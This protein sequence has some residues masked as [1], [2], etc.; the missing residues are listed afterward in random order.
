MR[1]HLLYICS[2]DELSNVAT[3]LNRLYATTVES[4]GAVAEA[5][6]L[7]HSLLGDTVL[8]I[9]ILTDLNAVG[10]HLR[11][12]PVDLLIYDERGDGS[13][14]APDAVRLIKK[15]V[16]ALADLWGPDFLFPM[17][18]VVA[19][20]ERQ[21]HLPEHAFELGQL[22][23]RDVC[24]APK[25]TAALVLWLKRILAE[26]VIK[27]NRV[28]L[29]L[30]GGGLEGFLYQLG[31]LYALEQS[32]EG[33]ELNH[34]DVVSGVSSGSIVGSLFA[35][36]IS[37]D[38]VIK[39]LHQKS[40]LLPS[41]TS[42]AIFDIAGLEIAQ[43]L[44]KQ[45]LGWAGLSP[46]KWLSKISGSVPTGFFRG[47]K[48][49]LFFRDI[50]TETVE[51]DDNF[52]NFKS[53]LF[54]GATD[55][56]SYEHVIFGLPPWDD[57]PVSEAVRASIALPPVFVPKSIKGRWFIDGQ[58]T[59]TTDLELVVDKGCSLV[60]II[61]PLKPYTSNTPGS[62]DKL[63]GVHGFIQTIKALVSSR[64][65]SS[66]KH[67]TE[68]FPSVDFIVFEPDEECAK[69]MSG[70]PMR[71]RIRTEI[72]QLAY[73]STLRKLRERREVYAVK[74][75]K[76]GYKLKSVHTL[77]KLEEVDLSQLGDE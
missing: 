26:G 56:D 43:R 17:S 39:S 23:I 57:V 20:I 77:K 65:E 73:L 19:I 45:S 13:T 72:V 70:S 7:R 15:D 22:D 31:C 33:R 69:V 44:M 27:E 24:V 6:E 11:S 47:S 5:F 50:F 21:D 63:G 37:L 25:N 1:Y 62:T 75:G 32:V 51:L 35:A 38:E 59:K 64:F 16:Q 4:G 76:Y 14:P 8:Q 29:S 67:V 28:G 46:Q 60:V 58:V 74:L 54:I 18:R 61:N 42:G 34:V 41:L 55:Q 52:K 9:N 2:K 53:E 66:L 3:A 10:G 36:G 49:E 40:D 30:S 71:Y 48:L 12:Y 68:R